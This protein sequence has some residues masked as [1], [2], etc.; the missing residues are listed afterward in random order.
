MA[1]GLEWLLK[2]DAQVD[3]ALKM[4]RVLKDNE[5]GLKSVE[6]ALGKTEAASG[7]AERGHKKHA[8]G[9]KHLEGALHRLVHAGIEPFLERAKRIAEFEFIR[10]GVDAIL[11]APGELI[12]KVRELGSEILRAAGAAEEAEITMKALFGGEDAEKLLDYSE[13]IADKTNETDDVVKSMMRDLGNAGFKVGDDMERALR[14]ASD[15]GALSGRGAAGAQEAAAMLERLQNMGEMNPRMLNAF[16][17]KREDFWHELSRQTGTGIETL[18]KQMDKGKV[19][20][21]MTKAA[22]YTL[23]TEKTHQGLGGLGG[24]IGQDLNSRMMR[25]KNAPDRIFDAMQKSAG[26]AKISDLIGS[27]GDALSPSSPGGQQIIMGLTS[28]VDKVGEMAK[29]FDVNRFVTDLTTTILPAVKDIVN[30]LAT[31]DWGRGMDVLKNGLKIIKPTIDAIGKMMDFAATFH[32]GTNSV[33]GG[34]GSIVK[35]ALHPIDTWKAT[36]HQ[37][38]G[39]MADALTGSGKAAG[40]GLALGMSQSRPGVA[41]QSQ[42]LAM[43]S[44]DAVSS[45]LDIH[46]PS[47]VFRRL[48]EMSATGFEE[49]LARGQDSVRSAS[50]S[51]VAPEAPAAGG[52]SAPVSISL[53]GIHISVAGGGADGVVDEI[54]A[55]LERILPAKF[56]E[57]LEAAGMQMGAAR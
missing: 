35:G 3:G 24:D 53:G 42:A 29:G 45:S 54:A 22:I 16:G 2:L 32:E 17:L 6:R 13:R 48:G 12:E 4:I 30:R 9:A 40:A 52:G 19:D 27:L 36:L 14:A 51:L 5:D 23:I 37:V 1:D 41:A 10:K 50:M 49:G 31:V 21:E 18:K 34:I 47:R 33:A 38:T 44:V 55:K 20:I 43:S 7:H 15:L 28:I 39:K 26:F 11:D 46:S 8:D 57:A 25:L 56:V